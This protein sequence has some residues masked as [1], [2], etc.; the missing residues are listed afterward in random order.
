[1]DGS[2]PRLLVVED[3]ATLQR[4][5]SLFAKKLGYDAVVVGLAT[6]ALAVVDSA[7]F[8][9]VLMDLRL[10]DMDGHEC[11]K[12]MR[13]A[14][15]TIP[16]VALTAHNSMEDRKISLES[17]MNDFMSKAYTLGQFRSMIERWVP[18]AVN[19]A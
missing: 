11:A 10:P 2:P 7:A 17:G 12:A 8:D 15:P 9:L 14:N 19:K 4:V 5:V 18:G 13:L 1:M 16:I 6:E 3:D